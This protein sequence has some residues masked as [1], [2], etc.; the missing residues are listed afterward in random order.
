[1]RARTRSSPGFTI[2]ELAVIALILSLMAYISI[3]GIS[4]RSESDQAEN[5][6]LRLTEVWNAEK[7]YYAYKGIYTEDWLALGMK[8]PSAEDKFYDYA[9]HFTGNNFQAT[10]TRQGKGGGFRIDKSGTPRKF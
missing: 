2:A 8:D 9:I 10:A 3:R 6:K 7:R 5:A 4:L 1:M